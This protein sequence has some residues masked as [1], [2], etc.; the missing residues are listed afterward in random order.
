MNDLGI[1]IAVIALIVGSFVVMRK[2]Y[3]RFST[4]LLNPVL[5]TTFFIIIVL[6]ILKIPY[7]DFMVGGKWIQFFLGPT[8]VSLAFPLYRQR[9]ILVKYRQAIF[10]GVGMGIISAMLSVY[11]LAIIARVDQEIIF[12]LLPKSLTMPVA[13]QMSTTLGGIPPMSAAFVMI[14]GFTGLILGPAFMKMMHI[15]T[16]LSK[17]LS[18]GSA[19]HALGVA[20]ATEYGE[21]A[22]SMSS[23][24]MT[25]SAIAG[26]VIGPL[27]IWVMTF[28]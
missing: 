5:T 2:L 20:K 14:A 12:T 8:V 13:L 4:P 19:S 3:A 18:L 7:D 22:L 10:M 6:I 24:S 28:G 9:E 15:D 26:S 25:L 27:I 23:V 17:G 21:F 16:P 1:I 11:L